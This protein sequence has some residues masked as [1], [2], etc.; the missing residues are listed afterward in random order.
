MTLRLSPKL[1][2]LAGA[3]FLAAFVGWADLITG[4]HVSVLA[5]Y[6]FP[7]VIAV[8]WVGNAGGF[9]LA[10]FSAVVCYYVRKITADAPHLTDGVPFWNGLMRFTTFMLFCIGGAAVRFKVETL[11]RQ[12]KMLTGIL[13]F[14]IAARKSRTSRATG[15]TWRLICTS[16]PTRMWSVSFARIAHGICGRENWP[17]PS[18]PIQPPASPPDEDSALDSLG[19]P[20]RGRPDRGTE[21]AFHAERVAGALCGSGNSRCARPGLDEGFPLAAPRDGALPAQLRIHLP[22]RPVAAEAPPEL[23]RRDRER[24]LAIQ[25]LRRLAGPAR[26]HAR[27]TASSPTGCSIP[28]SRKPTRSSI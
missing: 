17:N 9:L 8:W 1:L 25:Q 14:V 10:L 15:M 13:P 7:I 11:R 24:H 12:V 19:Q 20:A 23:R 22:L 5:F 2:I 28:G 3:H 27:L 6:G 4:Y 26:G 21:A 16:I 18:R